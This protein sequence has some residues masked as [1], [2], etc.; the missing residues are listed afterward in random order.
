M[1]R[2]GHVSMGQ[3]IIDPAMAAQL[4][5]QT[6]PSKDEQRRVAALN[7]AIASK[8]EG[9]QLDRELLARAKGID[10]FIT[11]GNVKNPD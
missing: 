2:E 11:S 5:G 4:G 7:F 9:F 10:H 3:G 8:P 1:G 6:A